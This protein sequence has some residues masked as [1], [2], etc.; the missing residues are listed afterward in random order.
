ME[1]VWF[2]IFVSVFL[3]S[4]I[5]L[6]GVVAFGVRQEKL[7]NLLIYF[8]SFSAGALLGDAFLHLI[9]EATRKNGF[10]LEVA[11][12]ILSGIL[13]FFILEKL[14]HWHHC[15]ES[16][17]HGHKH[18]VTY[19]S[20]VGDALHNFIDGVIIAASYLVSLPV[21]FATT[22]AVMFHEIPHELGS[23]SILVHGGF[24]KSKALLY[25][26]LSA[27]TAFGGAFAVFLLGSL[28]ENIQSILVPISAGTFIYIAG[29]D[30]LPELHKHSSSLMKS[31]VQL[32]AFILGILLMT[33]FL[34]FE[35]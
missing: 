23:Y 7:K 14:I 8:V 24:S 34:I 28:M 31:L 10:G 4:L 30:L 18:P 32:F 3:V 13:V 5:S 26:F 22:L 19:I 27:L 11:L 16:T 35:V 9:P 33:F 25:N 29:S 6:I 17:D 12:C 20:L 2:Y 15:H 21:G 1:I